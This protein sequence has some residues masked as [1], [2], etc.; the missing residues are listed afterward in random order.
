MD[1]SLI[2]S[3][4][5]LHLLSLSEKKEE[6]LQ[7]IAEI[8]AEIVRTLKGGISV[9]VVNVVPASRP[10]L[11]APAQMLNK[12]SAAPKKSPAKPAKAKKR[13]KMSPEGRA[14]IAAMMKARWA[15]R[16]AAK[17]TAKS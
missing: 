9:E 7:V 4:S 1:L 10:A 12:P 15:A 14:K 16:R 11:A 13:S 8:N 3:Q 17:E 2:N 5:L 6:I